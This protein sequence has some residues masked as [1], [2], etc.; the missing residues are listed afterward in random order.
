MSDATLFANVACY[1]KI[2][3]ERGNS[4]CNW[5]VV[6]LGCAASER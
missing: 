4:I 5:N 2:K 1:G 3:C 6:P